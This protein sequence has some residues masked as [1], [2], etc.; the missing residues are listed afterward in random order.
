MA[1]AR[2]PEDPRRRKNY[3]QTV[4][5]RGGEPS[6][7]LSVH[8]AGRGAGRGDGVARRNSKASGRDA[9]VWLSADHDGT[10]TW[11]LGGES[12]TSAPADTRP[13]T[14][15]R[16]AGGFLSHHRLRPPTSEGVR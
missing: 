14:A 12:Q 11:R 8:Q 16:A 2:L 15:V 10:A 6:R 9:S 5:R 3:N 1:A 13:Q 7:I 4:P